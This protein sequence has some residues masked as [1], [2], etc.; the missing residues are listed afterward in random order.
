MKK[1]LLLA[2]ALLSAAAVFTPWAQRAG[3]PEPRA[4]AP[5]GPLLPQEQ[6]LANLFDSTAP[7]VAYITTEVLEQTGFFTA[8]GG[9]GRGQRL[10][11]GRGRATSSPTSTCWRARAASR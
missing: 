8:A 1:P 9:A 6:A 7:S 11:L 3:A 5:R 4:V 10:R 2:A